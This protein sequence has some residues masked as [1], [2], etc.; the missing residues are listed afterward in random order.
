[1]CILNGDTLF[2]IDFNQLTTI[3]QDSQAAITLALKSMNDASRYG[4]VT[5]SSEGRILSLMR[6][7]WVLRV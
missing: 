2:D 3:H 5:L 1:M 4:T 6:S 7:K